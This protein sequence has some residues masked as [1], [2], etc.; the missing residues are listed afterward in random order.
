VGAKAPSGFEREMEREMKI[1]FVPKEVVEWVWN[2]LQPQQRFFGEIGS[3]SVKL[4]WEQ[5]VLVPIGSDLSF[6]MVEPVITEEFTLKQF[7]EMIDK[8]EYK[9]MELKSVE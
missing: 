6:G 5:A 9:K 8:E 4:P 3:R 2:R 1:I 7:R